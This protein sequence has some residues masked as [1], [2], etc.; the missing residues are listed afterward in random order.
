MFSYSNVASKFQLS[1]T[2]CAYLV[3]FGIA[4][5]INESL[6]IKILASPFFSVSFDE[7]LNFVLE[8]QQMDIHIR[9][10][11]D[12]TKKIETRY[13]DS[14]FQYRGNADQ[15]VD[16]LTTSLAPLQVEKRHHLSMDGP[17]VNWCVFSKIQSL[18]EEE[19]H[20]VLEDIDSCS[21]HTVSNSFQCG[22]KAAEW[23]VEKLLQGMYKFLNKSPARR[24]DFVTV[25]SN[26]IFP[27]KFCPTRWVENEN[28]SQRALELWGDYVELI[29]EYLLQ[30]PS[31]RPKDNKFLITWWTLIG[32]PLLK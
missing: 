19:E 15:L 10:W 3:N 17:N 11:S 9:F 32:T 21:L 14:Q 7:S 5:Y 20:P 31:K 25:S 28:V 13:W 4:P 29:K 23:G 6:K 27:L 1:K 22:V 18:R 16:S 30:P 24:G 12:E 8:K 2:K 26:E